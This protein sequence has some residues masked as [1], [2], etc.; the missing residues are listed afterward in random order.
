MEVR[1][2]AY[3]GLNELSGRLGNR[4][5]Y[6]GE[7]FPECMIQKERKKEGKIKTSHFTIQTAAET[8]SL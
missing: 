3:L 6:R 5:D 4:C 2:F 7:L 1:T 8:I